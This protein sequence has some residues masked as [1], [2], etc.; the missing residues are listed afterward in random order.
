[1]ARRVLAL[2]GV[3]FGAISVLAGTRVLAGIDSPDYVVLRWLV[4]YNVFGG[5]AAVVAGA[6]LWAHRD[7]GPLAARLVAS[8]HAGVLGVLIV[9]RVFGADVANDSVVAMAARTTLWLLL[10]KAPRP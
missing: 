1:M 4:F 2:A 7:W 6:A 5:V 10:A 9:L 3:A 8:A